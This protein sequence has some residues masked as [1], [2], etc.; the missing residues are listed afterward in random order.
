[1]LRKTSQ[2][3]KLSASCKKFKRQKENLHILKVFK[4]KQQGCETLC[5]TKSLKISQGSQKVYPTKITKKKE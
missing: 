5:F 1:M 4:I 3:A 2:N